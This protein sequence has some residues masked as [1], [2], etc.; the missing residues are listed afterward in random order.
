MPNVIDK[1]KYFEDEQ[2]INKFVRDSK[3][4]NPK[5]S[6]YFKELQQNQEEFIN[7]K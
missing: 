4:A 7:G 5:P 6:D 1:A 2:R 3:L